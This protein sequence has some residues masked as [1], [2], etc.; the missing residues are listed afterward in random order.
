MLMANTA[1]GF[2]GSFQ[3]A[4]LIYISIVYEALPF[5][6]FG[7][8]IAGLLEELLPP[9]LLV[10]MLPKS[11][12][13]GILGGG[14]LGIIF[15]MCECGIVPIM[16]RLLRKGLP[17]STSTAYLLAGPVINVVV[18][19][20]TYFAFSGMEETLD[21]GGKLAYQMGGVAMTVSR[22]LLAYLVAVLVS[23][24]VEFFFISQG[25]QALIKESSLPG[26]NEGAEEKIR[27]MRPN[28]RIARIS[29][30][31]LH[32]F[33]DI[34]TFLV[35]GAGLAA[36]VRFFV[37]HEMISTWT[38]SN[39]VLAILLMMGLAILLCLCSE[40]DAFVAAS[41]VKMAPAA[42]L[43]FLVLGPMCDFKLM[44]L[45]TRVF[46]PKLIVFIFGLVIL[47]SFIGS[48]GVHY[49]WARV[50]PMIMVD[51]NSVPAQTSSR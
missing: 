3:Q 17:L 23:V 34:T 19:T 29:G 37:T 33:V 6:L 18:L 42:K 20:S 13:V 51:N 40:A 5:I 43:S 47:L 25:A 9:K 15:P 12:F 30:T 50:A 22:G 38:D 31:I 10:R 14:L 45:Y 7:A 2:F 26:Q 39:I 8:M 11:R 16:R 49:I 4:I 24:A 44:A 1:N 46:K 21:S 35:L 28:A 41:M 27:D 48:L 32:D 36:T